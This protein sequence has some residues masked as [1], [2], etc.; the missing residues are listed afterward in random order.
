MLGG[1]SAGA[2]LIIEPGRGKKLRRRP[3]NREATRNLSKLGNR[4]RDVGRAPACRA[5]YST[6]RIE[7]DRDVREMSALRAGAPAKARVMAAR[8]E[9]GIY[10]NGAHFRSGKMRADTRARNNGIAPTPLLIMSSPRPSSACR[11]VNARWGNCI[12]MSSRRHQMPGV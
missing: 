11:Q 7:R 6:G 10:R 3:A 5:F 1:I 9:R 8:S 2:C 4:K 12:A